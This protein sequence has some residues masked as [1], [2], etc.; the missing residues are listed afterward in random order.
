MKA[1]VYRHYGPAEVL[2]LS[3]V[4]KPEPAENEVLIRVRAVEVTKSDCE[5]RSLNFP[6]SWFV[7][8]LRL[9][10]GWNRPRKPILGSYF[11]G[12]VVEVGHKVTRFKPGDALYGCSQFRFGAY[13]EYLALPETYTLA[14]K[15]EN[16]TYAEAAS[17]PLGGLNAL[18]FINR[19]K[20]KPGD[21]MLINGAGGS[22]GLLAVQLAKRQGTVITAVDRTDKEAIIHLAGAE[23]FIDYTR[24]SFTRSLTPF[25]VVFNMV[26]S[27]RHS[28]CIK[29]LAPGGHYLTGNPT[30]GD[31]A[32]AP[33]TRWVRKKRVTLALAK[34]TPAELATLTT[35][36]EAGELRPLV[37]EVLPIERIVE[38]HRR[39]ETEQRLGAIVVTL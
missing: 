15:P 4:H 25:D 32:Q 37:D 38:A 3:D 34:E 39:V 2:E 7:P 21:R 8:P 6:V 12:D 9:V 29:V 5:L 19:A 13:G 11:A 35:L 20:L 16:L 28:D 23:R 31:W 26:A 33:W 22:I 27:A 10:L 36:L 17:I 30:L 1:V 18:H 14:P 24:E